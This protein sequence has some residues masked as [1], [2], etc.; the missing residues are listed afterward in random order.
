MPSSSRSLLTPRATSCD[1]RPSCKFVGTEAQCDA[2]RLGIGKSFA[3]LNEPAQLAKERARFDEIAAMVRDDT[4]GDLVR[5]EGAK[6]M[7]IIREHWVG[8]DQERRLNKR[9]VGATESL[10]KKLKA[11][12]GRAAEVNKRREGGR[13]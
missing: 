2:H 8:P 5:A 13:G 7:G 12:N 9:L 10:A 1:C 4:V 11:A 3:A 6:I